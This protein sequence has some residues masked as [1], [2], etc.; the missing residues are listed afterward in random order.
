MAQLEQTES[1]EN[2]TTAASSKARAI[3]C[4]PSQHAAKE[5]IAAEPS[6]SEVFLMI[7]RCLSLM[8]RLASRCSASSLASR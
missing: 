7:R 5:P 8:I 2:Q 1:L 3:R 6:V 4:V